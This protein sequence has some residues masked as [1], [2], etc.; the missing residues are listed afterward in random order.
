MTLNSIIQYKEKQL[1][2]MAAMASFSATAAA[3]ETLGF[4]RRAWCNTAPY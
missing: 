3:V 4:T 1:V 2:T